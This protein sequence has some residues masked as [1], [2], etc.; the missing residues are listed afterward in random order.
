MR[1]SWFRQR[2]STCCSE[3]T[4]IE[5]SPTA[6]SIRSR[7]RRRSCTGVV[8]H[9]L[10]AIAFVFLPLAL[11]A[12]LTHHVLHQMRHG[13]A[14]RLARSAVDR[15]RV[16]V[17]RGL[18]GATVDHR[19]QCPQPFRTGARFGAR[20]PPIAPAERRPTVAT[21]RVLM[22]SAEPA[23]IASVLMTPAGTLV[24]PPS[25]PLWRFAL[26]GLGPLSAMGV[27]ALL[28]ELIHRLG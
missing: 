13:P 22:G 27:F 6:G 5:A 10:M 15:L 12:V 24:A 7:I 8:A 16:P 28:A 14:N 4:A 9:V 18:S 3:A 26:I 1:R 21:T 11:I 23:P 2:C 17:E 19:L 20:R 25:Q